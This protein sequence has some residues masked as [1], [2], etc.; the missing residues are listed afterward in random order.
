M[1]SE[2]GWQTA[3]PLNGPYAVSK[4]AVEALGDSSRRELSLLDMSVVKIQPGA[5]RTGMVASLMDR[6]ER[7]AADSTHYRRVLL[8]ATSASRRRSS[9]PATPMTS[10]LW[11]SAC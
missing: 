2:T 8:A 11:S 7:L 6:F 10:L 4:H 1:S 3:M 9:A 5:F